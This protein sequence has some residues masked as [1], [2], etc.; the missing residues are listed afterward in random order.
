MRAEAAARRMKRN[1]ETTAVRERSGIS[2]ASALW[3]FNKQDYIMENRAEVVR[4][5]YESIL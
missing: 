5:P 1:I 4:K 3:R 2:G